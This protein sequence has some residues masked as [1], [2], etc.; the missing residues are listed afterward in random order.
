GL[1]WWG[2]V[3]TPDRSWDGLVSWSFRAHYLAPPADLNQPFFTDPAVF[4]HSATYPLLQPLVLG[5]SQALL[6][7]LWGRSVF[8]LWMIACVLL[9]AT[10]LSIH[11]LRSGYAALGTLAFALTPMWYSIGSGAV[12]SGYAELLLVLVLLVAGCGLLLDH[13][14]MVAFGAFLLPLVKP[15]GLPYAVLLCLVAGLDRSVRRTVHLW[16]CGGM[17]IGLLLWLPLRQFLAHR[18]PTFAWWPLALGAA[19]LVGTELATRV[20]PRRAVPWL[21][22][23]VGMAAVL[24]CTVFP[25]PLETL[26]AH[27]SPGLAVSV[28]HLSRRFQQLPTMLWGYVQG[29]LFA[30]KFGLIFPLLGLI[31]L[32]PRRFFGPSPR[33]ALVG[34]VVGGVA[35]GCGS[36]WFS[37]EGLEHE[38]ESRFD[39]L[40]LHWVGPAW[41]LVFAWIG[42]L[43]DRRVAADCPATRTR[44]AP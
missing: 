35:M 44:L 2:S 37:P 18:P 21:L 29:L 19:L 23:L 26:L 7:P 40:L 3:V 12:D 20:L 39:R 14:W 34:L 5:A 16:A 8:P 17:V 32:A 22:A 10:T 24:V 30:R 6:G 43:A 13:A 9:V 42:G 41:L 4:A 31:L 27:C 36:V 11:G 33:P 25:Q 28:D 1:S 15:E 38:L